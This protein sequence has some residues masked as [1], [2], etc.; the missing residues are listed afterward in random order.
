MEGGFLGHPL[1]KAQEVIRLPRV[2]GSKLKMQPL[3]IGR[4]VGRAGNWE[5][6]LEWL[7]PC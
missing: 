4:K 3:C 2:K 6:D 1:S 5:L 7:F